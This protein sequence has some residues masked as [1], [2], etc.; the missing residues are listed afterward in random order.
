MLGTVR[1]RLLGAAGFTSIRIEPWDVPPDLVDLFLYSGKHWP[2]RY[3]SADFRRA[4]S[5]FSQ[6]ADPAEVDAGCARLRAD[7]ASGRI[8]AVRR[9]YASP[10]GDYAFVV[11]DRP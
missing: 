7:I 9:A 1:R 10:R 6:H 4:I 11:A 2:E 8:D 5:T 3:L